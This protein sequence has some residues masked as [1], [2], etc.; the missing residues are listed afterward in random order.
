M[1][2]GKNDLSDAV[3]GNEGK[4]AKL[5][6]KPPRLPAVQKHV[7]GL[8]MPIRVNVHTGMNAA[9]PATKPDAPTGGTRKRHRTR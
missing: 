5:H 4:P 8:P 1:S 6:V 7:R 3:T 9:P 2:K